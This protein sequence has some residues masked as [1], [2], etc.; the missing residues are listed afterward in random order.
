MATDARVQKCAVGAFKPD[1]PFSVSTADPAFGSCPRESSAL[2]VGP[3]S[4][5]VNIDIGVNF[6]CHGG[7]LWQWS[8]TR[9]TLLECVGLK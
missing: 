7:W 8:P 2:N 1:L 9:S 6:W 3:G 4:A 5:A